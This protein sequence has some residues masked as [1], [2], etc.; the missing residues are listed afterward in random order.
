[1]SKN[2]KNVNFSIT[3][4]LLKHL[5]ELAE[6]SDRSLS[7]QIRFMLTQYIKEHNNDGNI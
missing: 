3:E 6:A 2:T 1:M 4:E 7:A 5:M